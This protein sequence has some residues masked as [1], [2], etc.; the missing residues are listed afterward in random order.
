M[1]ENIMFVDIML[2]NIMFFCIMFYS[3]IMRDWDYEIYR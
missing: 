1:R 2:K 3:I